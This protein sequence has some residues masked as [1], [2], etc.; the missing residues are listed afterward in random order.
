[1]KGKTVELKETPEP[2]NAEVIDLM[3]RLRQSLA[4]G[5]RTRKN[6]RTASSKNR[7]RPAASA[8]RKRAA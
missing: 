1:M 8:K 5:G 7:K 2:Q 4:G 6:A 3:E